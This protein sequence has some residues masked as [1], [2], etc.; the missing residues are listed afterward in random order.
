M[1]YRWSVAVLYLTAMTL[2]IYGVLDR[3]TTD[4]SAWLPVLAL[5]QV[6]AGFL[7]GRWGAVLLPLALIPISVPAMDPPITPDNAEPFPV[8]ISVGFLSLLAVPIV[9]AG[10]IGRAIYEAHRGPRR[11][12]SARGVESS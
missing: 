4:G 7:I 1:R 12:T 10:L 6:A 5:V 8:F 9:A 3:S 2:W 11:H